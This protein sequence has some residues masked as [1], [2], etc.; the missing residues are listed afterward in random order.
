[1]II[2]T[3]LEKDAKEISELSSQLGYPT[4]E[5][6]TIENIRRINADND[7]RVFVAELDE[8]VVGWIQVQKR[9]ML[10]STPFVEI[11]GLIVEANHR[12]RNIGRSL[13][14]EGIR[15]AKDENIQSLRVRSNAIREE[16]HGFYKAIGFREVKMQKVYDWDAE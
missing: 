10:I 3:V 2:R 6:Q 12:N 14:H 1:M 8:F 5:L 7:Q 9:I 16:S 4:G 13:V 11:V 15:W